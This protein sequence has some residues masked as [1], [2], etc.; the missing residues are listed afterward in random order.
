MLELNALHNAYIRPSP[1]R[2]QVG[3][4]TSEVI[5]LCEAAGYDTVIVETV[6]TGQS[7]V[8]VRG[9]VDCFLLLLPPAAGDELQGLKKGI[10]EVADIIAVTKADG[11]TQNLAETT[12]SEYKGALRL[13]GCREHEWKRQVLPI[14]SRTGA[15]LDDLWSAVGDFFL[16]QRTSIESTRSAYRGASFYRLLSHELLIR[17]PEVAELRARQ[18]RV[19]HG[20]SPPATAAFQ[21]AT[22]L[23]AVLHSGQVPIELD[24]A[25]DSL[26]TDTADL[27]GR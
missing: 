14:S 2:G 5:T 8:A 26:P 23:S 11:T 24:R 19:E 6:G 25:L 1:S 4:S 18:H 22:A 12:V 20:D 16:T 17:M 21:A 27:P 10:V 9:L 15:G 3:A 13:L 7:E